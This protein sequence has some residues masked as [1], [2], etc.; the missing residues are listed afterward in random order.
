MSHRPNG[1]TG[2]EYHALLKRKPGAAGWNWNVM[3]RDPT[4]FVRGAVSHSDH[5]TIRLD[6]WH[7]VLMNTENE[8]RAAV[9][10][11]FLD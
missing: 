11:T 5:A 1:L 8:S 10:V 9:S 2:S 3:Q 7:R 4:V 6:G